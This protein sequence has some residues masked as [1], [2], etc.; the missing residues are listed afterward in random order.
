MLFQF[1]YNAGFKGNAFGNPLFYYFLS[2]VL[3]FG[4]HTRGLAF[5]TR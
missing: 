5:L 3:E 4:L 2:Q 1:A